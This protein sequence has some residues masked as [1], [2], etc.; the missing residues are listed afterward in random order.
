VT[1]T[2]DRYFEVVLMGEG[3][4]RDDVGGSLAASDEGRALVH[5]SVVDATRVVVAGIAR[6]EEL[7]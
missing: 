1:S 7:P 2:T 3:D 4:G 6:S 5:H